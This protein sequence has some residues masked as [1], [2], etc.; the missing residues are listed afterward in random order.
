MD[1]D[2][3]TISPGG[4]AGRSLGNLENLKACIAAE[5]LKRRV[6][7]SPSG[8][9]ILGY[10]RLEA[11]RQLGWRRVSANTATTV[12][13]ALAQMREDAASACCTHPLTVTEAVHLD[14]A[15][16]ELPWGRLDVGSAGRRRRTE[17]AGL[18]GMNTHQY[19]AARELVL[20]ATCG[21]AEEYG[22]RRPVPDK[23]RERATFAL[24][25]VEAPSDLGAALRM[26][27][28]GDGDPPPPP[29]RSPRRLRVRGG[30]G[31]IDTALA[32]LMGVTTGLAGATIAD[33]DVSSGVLQR[34]DRDLGQAIR[35][36]AKLR[37][38]VQRHDGYSDCGDD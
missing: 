2:I 19:T 23:D 24:A 3:A 9:L 21:Y 10:R 31:S 12:G 8:R 22:I 6:T 17:I 26:Y 1:M 5:G 30:E 32:T 29:P 28:K 36:L 16:R 20:A 38:E 15:L 35:V 13:E 11:C 34:W 25:T 7:I 4:R 14:L 27:R 37:K 18:L 33:L